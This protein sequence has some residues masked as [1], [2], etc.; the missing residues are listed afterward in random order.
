MARIEQPKS[1]IVGK[2]EGVHLFHF[3]GAPCAQRVRFALHEK[4]LMRGREVRFD[5]DDPASSKGEAGAWVSRQVSLVKKEH[6]TA[7]YAQIQPNLVVP[8]LVHDGELHIESMDIVEYLDEAFGGTPLVPKHNPELMADAQALTDLGKALHRSIR[9]VTFRW[10]L[11]GLAR[12]SAKEERQLQELLRNAE[13]GEQLISFYEGY[14]KKSIPDA[15]YVEHL[16]KLNEA[17]R[18]HEER[19]RDGR[20]FLS[21]DNLT[22]A[23]IIWAMKT[24]RLLECDY[25]FEQCFPGCFAWFQ[26]ISGRPS[27]QQGVMGKH[28]LMS[29]A[30]R[31]KASI[32]HLLGIG[33]KREVLKRVAA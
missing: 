13:D 23:D 3:D 29:T 17:F 31:A 24:L 18:T 5:A 15:V 9:F 12:L 27:F 20:H 4:G 22:M 1:P 26:R 21:G 10:G 8:A 19:L 30:F 25:P 28:R 16:E 14:D 33:L 11:R 6:M 32:E 7:T 2:L